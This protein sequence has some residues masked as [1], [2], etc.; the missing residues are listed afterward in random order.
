MNKSLEESTLLEDIGSSGASNLRGNTY[1]DVHLNKEYTILSGYS[2]VLR[3]INSSFNILYE[4]DSEPTRILAKDHAEDLRI[5][6][7]EE[8]DKIKQS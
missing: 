8:N 2:G 3:A 4:E 5:F 7:K 6:K 1:L